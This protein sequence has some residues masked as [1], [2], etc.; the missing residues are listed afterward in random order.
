M[1]CKLP[2]SLKVGSL[3]LPTTLSI[4]ACA[5]SWTSGYRIIVIMSVVRVVCV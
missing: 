1:Y 4:I 5:R 2:L 3:S